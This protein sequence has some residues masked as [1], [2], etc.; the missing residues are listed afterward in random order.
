VE[1]GLVQWFPYGDVD[2]I[3]RVV[4]KLEALGVRRLRTQL[5]WADWCRADG[6]AWISRLLDE[7]REIDVF[8]VLHATPPS[9]GE[10]PYT[11]SVPRDLGTYAYFVRRMCEDHGDHFEYVQLWN[12][13]TTWNEW[14]RKADPWWRRFAEMIGFAANEAR[15]RGKRVV[16]AGISPPDGLLLGR[17]DPDQPHFLEI[18]E[19]EGVLACV[20]VVAFHGFP[21]TPHWC[22]G[23]AGWDNE[24]AAI[25][26]WADRR[27][28]ET[29][30]TETGSSRLMPPR[31][32]DELRRVVAAAERG[33]IERVYWYSV[34]DVDWRSLREINLPWPPD[35]HDYATGLTADA[36]SVIR[37][38]VAR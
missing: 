18:M 30:I 22:E 15:A 32:A 24:I 17:R 19:E 2:R 20:D 9:F 35:P 34:E 23:W 4:A 28:L 36:E 3:R 11:S 10:I 7:L 37:S 29:W 31:L 33:G 21:G 14:D 8:P 27:N 12:E 6:P 25:R 1:L 16:L 26:G 13:P 38:V 5:S